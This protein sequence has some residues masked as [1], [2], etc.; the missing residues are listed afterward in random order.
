MCDIIGTVEENYGTQ[1]GGMARFVR[2]EYFVGKGSLNVREL[3]K[4][5]VGLRVLGL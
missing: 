1:E 2:E 3:G 4:P 5:V